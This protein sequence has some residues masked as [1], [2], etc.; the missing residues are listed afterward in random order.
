MA[1]RVFRHK[2]LSRI[3]MAW[4]EIYKE[5][6]INTECRYKNHQSYILVLT[7]GFSHE[8]VHRYLADEFGVL[9]S[10]KFDRI[11]EYVG[12]C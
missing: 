2:D 1:L 7:I 9:I 8:V 4:S 6:L 11:C 12:L 5:L 3:V 10:N